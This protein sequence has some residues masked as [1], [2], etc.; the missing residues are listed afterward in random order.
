MPRSIKPVVFRYKLGE[1]PEYY[2]SSPQEGIRELEEIRRMLI[3]VTGNPDLPIEKVVVQR[4][5]PWATVPNSE[6]E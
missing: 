1:Q 2:A 6:A 5:A 3:S 4:R